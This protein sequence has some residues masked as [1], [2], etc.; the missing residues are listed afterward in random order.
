MGELLNILRRLPIFS[1]VSESSLRKIAGKFVTIKFRK[2]EVV[3]Y[4]NEESTD[5][6]VVLSG[7]LRAVVENEEG[8]EL[9]LAT[10]KRGDFFGE[11]SLFDGKPRSATVIAEEESLLALLSR[12]EF[13][14]LLKEE[15]TIAIEII[16]SL[17]RRLRR[18]DE[19]IEALAFLDVGERILKFLKEVGEREGEYVRVKKLK[20]RELAQRVGASREAVTKALKVL[21][22]RKILKEE[23]DYLLLRCS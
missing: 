16:V 12:D 8:K 18:A 14:K 7:K 22:H 23:G 4:Q 6:Y 13:L 20:H 21:I 1:K 10:F 2:N 19:T 11:M 15:P 3:F 9:L 17:V 5:L